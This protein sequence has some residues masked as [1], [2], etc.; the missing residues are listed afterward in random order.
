MPPVA[1]ADLTEQLQDEGCPTALRAAA[2]R[3]LVD[4]ESE[5]VVGILASAVDEGVREVRYYALMALGQIARE[6][7]ARALQAKQALLA[8]LRG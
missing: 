2:A 5:K 3:T 4:L 1:L 7:G 6:G 8:A